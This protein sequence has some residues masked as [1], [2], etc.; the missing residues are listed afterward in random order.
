MEGG[1][2]S[3]VRARLLGDEATDHSREIKYRIDNLNFEKSEEVVINNVKIEPLD[4]CELV[5]LFILNF[6]YLIVAFPFSCCAMLY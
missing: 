5:T 4:T 3:E 2:D 1:A 6:L